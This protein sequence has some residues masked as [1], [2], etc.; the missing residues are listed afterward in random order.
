MNSHS[1]LI[2]LIDPMCVSLNN[3]SIVQSI[4]F[5]HKGRYQV[6]KDRLG[7]SDIRKIGSEGGSMQFGGIDL[8][9]ETARVK[10][11][12]F[13]SQA[14]PVYLDIEHRNG[15]FSRFFGVITDM[16][17]D[18]PTGGVSPK[19]AVTMEVSHMITMDSSGNILSDGY[20]SLGG[21]ID[22]PSY[23]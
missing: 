1:V 5:V 9:G 18:H 22:E 12:E 11:Y 16:S 20:I 7:K 23:L 17:E 19:F 21:S 4:S 8:V 10:F 6:V 15:D 14:T 13:Q 2:D 3:F